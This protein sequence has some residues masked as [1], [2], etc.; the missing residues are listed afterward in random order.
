MYQSGNIP[1]VGTA[2]S[3]LLLLAFRFTKGGNRQ[4]KQ[5]TV[6]DKLKN[7]LERFLGIM[8]P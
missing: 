6:I 7:H 3:K 8:S 2:V 5:R 1:E 4:E